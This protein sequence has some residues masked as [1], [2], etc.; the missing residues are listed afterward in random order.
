MRFIVTY[1]LRPD[2]THDPKH[3]VTGG[4]PLSDKICTDVTGEHHSELVEAASLDEASS[5]AQAFGQ[6]VTRVEEA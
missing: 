2:L 6:R 1:R 3:K 5:L 4:C